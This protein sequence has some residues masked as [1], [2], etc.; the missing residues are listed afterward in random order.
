MEQFEIDNALRLFEEEAFDD[1]FDAVEPKSEDVDYL[2]LRAADAK[3]ATYYNKYELPT[4]SNRGELKEQWRRDINRFNQLARDYLVAGIHHQGRRFVDF[5]AM[6]QLSNNL[7]LSSSTLW[8]PHELD[9]VLSKIPIVHASSMTALSGYVDFVSTPKPIPTIRGTS[10]YNTAF[11]LLCR[12]LVRRTFDSPAPKELRL[13][14]DC[15]LVERLQQD[16]RLFLKLIGLWLA[17]EEV[18]TP[19]PQADTV[20]MAIRTFGLPQQQMEGA[21]IHCLLTGYGYF[22]ILHEFGHIVSG[23]WRRPHETWTEADELKADEFAIMCL[24]AGS[25]EVSEAKVFAL[26]GAHLFLA[27]L[28][29]GESLFGRDQRHAG[30]RVRS[31]QVFDMTVS[32]LTGIEYEFY[33]FLDHL[34]LLPAFCHSPSKYGGLTPLGRLD[35]FGDSSWPDPFDDTDAS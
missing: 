29:L 30:A 23:D 22:E 10:I 9:V 28:Q 34:E 6:N 1:L 8:T 17:D 18:S 4:Y 11:L 12:L 19:P 32:G 7:G 24:L 20:E 35:R 3:Y 21:A 25:H 2:K 13:R 31:K 16:T 15:Y 27:A 33:S 14:A 26:R 5:E